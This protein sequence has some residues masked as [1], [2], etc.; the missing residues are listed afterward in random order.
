MQGC[1][2]SEMRETACEAWKSVIENQRDT[3]GSSNSLGCSASCLR[4][5]ERLHL[6]EYLSHKK[7][8]PVK[9]LQ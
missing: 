9:T 5:R 3:E 7:K 4:R 2:E 1:M 6:Q 8:P